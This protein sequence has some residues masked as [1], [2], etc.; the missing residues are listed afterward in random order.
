[1]LHFHL[2]R[3]SLLKYLLLLNILLMI[4]SSDPDFEKNV[5]IQLSTAELRASCI[6][7]VSY[8]VSFALPKGILFLLNLILKAIP[9]VE[10]RL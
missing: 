1:M 10:K 5:Y 2:E 4:K 6:S 9:S 7:N 3:I 8:F